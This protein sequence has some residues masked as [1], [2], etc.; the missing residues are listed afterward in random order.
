MKMTQFSKDRRSRGRT[1]K[2]STAFLLFLAACSPIPGFGQQSTARISA[3]TPS[4]FETRSAASSAA[5]PTNVAQ[6]AHSEPTPSPSP[7]AATSSP[8]QGLQY[9]S[10][11]QLTQKMVAGLGDALQAKVENGIVRIQLPG[12]VKTEGR[13][14][15]Q[16]AAGCELLVDRANNRYAL[17]GNPRSVKAWQKLLK[18]MDTL[19][20]KLS[21]VEVIFCE[22]ISSLDVPRRLS[23][24]GVQ[25]NPLASS[26]YQVSW[27]KGSGLSPVARAGF[28]EDGPA[29]ETEP[30]GLESLPEAQQ[31]PGNA[32]DDGQ[33]VEVLPNALQTPLPAGVKVTVSEDGTALVIEGTEDEIRQ[34]RELYQRLKE[35][36]EQSRPVFETYLLEN[37]NNQA[38]APV[39]QELYDTSFAPSLGPATIS[40]VPG[41]NSLVISGRPE[42]ITEIRKLVER[43]DVETDVAGSFRV[44]RPKYISAASAAN[45]LGSFFNV[46]V[47]QPGA[48]QGQFNNNANDI[49]SVL[50]IPDPRS[51]SIIIKAGATALAQA[52]KLLMEIDIVDAGDLP[53]QEV[54]IIPLRNSVAADMAQ[55]IQSAIN[56]QVPGAPTATT[57]GNNNNPFGGGFG[58]Q[59]LNQQGADPT[60]A[61]TGLRLKLMT[62]DDETGVIRSGI[63]FDIQITA[64]PTSNSLVVRGPAESLPLVEELINQLDRLPNAASKI[65]V[66]SIVNGDAAQLYDML[67]QLF[68]QGQQQGGGGGFNFGQQNTGLTR[69]PLQT[70]STVQTLV[71]LRFTL[72]PR[73]NSII[74]SGSEGDLQVVED[75]LTLLDR[76]NSLRFITKMVRLSNLPAEDMADSLNEWI[77]ARQGLYEADPA[78]AAENVVV[79]QQIVVTPEPISNTLMITASPQ[80][81]I[82]VLE[83]V[84]MLD[85]RPPMVQIKVMIAEVT[86][87]D[88]EEFGLQ[89]GVQDS[90]LFDRGIGDGIGYNFNQAAI[91]N[92][93]GPLGLASRELLAGQGLVNLGVGR[94]NSTLGYGGLVL[95]AGNE[96]ISVLLRALKDKQRIRALSNPVLMT[97]DNLQARVQ[98]GQKVPYIVGV[99]QN[100][101]GGFNN[102]VELQ[103]VG[104]ILDVVPR[105]S[106]DGMITM[107]VNAQN[108]SI[109]SEAN[110][111]AIAVDSNGNTVRQA[112][113]NI[114]LAVTT[115]LARSGQTVVLGGLIRDTKTYAK[116][117]IPVLSDLPRVGPLFSF[118]SENELRTELL[119]FLT[120]TLVE[121]DTEVACT[122]QAEMDRMHWCIDDVIDLHGPIGVTDQGSIYN[123]SSPVVV[124]PDI[125]PTGPGVPAILSRGQGVQPVP[126]VEHVPSTF[127]M[128]H[129]QPTGGTSDLQGG[130]SV[131]SAESVAPLDVAPN[132]VAPS[133][134]P[135]GGPSARK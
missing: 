95:S 57:F 25:L 10:G 93:L 92:S 53:V 49:Q 47:Q 59:G 66:F 43:L 100:T 90:I 81:M 120:P 69:L 110:G 32:Q 94:T 15:T 56:G 132:Q 58:Q 108:S 88:T 6:A 62:I 23:A 111:T 37:A 9:I 4:A 3:L 82:E 12:Q 14:M 117:G 102:S 48:N 98:V 121:D 26:V 55:V 101:L 16:S 63:L 125:N 78:T 54:K 109:G 84:R 87:N 115:V 33:N 68:Q 126:G 73:T 11:E 77:T 80:N 17:K 27:N 34:F 129:A 38:L 130:Y 96:S 75:L 119:F 39:L 135:P 44:L 106:P 97:I 2:L 104:V 124:Y 86:L 72:E 60:P 118:Q 28:Q 18:S 46:T 74:A 29:Q 1:A 41:E 64:D 52:Q 131:E 71:N 30:Q 13:P 40:A 122:N 134:V 45:R 76:E 51:N 133:E 8:I 91:G 85:R 128:M 20:A 5:V 112:P 50:I 67:T 116:R 42:A 114:T 70:G 123:D 105:V 107:L 61:A 103:D 22:E 31:E 127:E 99:N 65:K 21:S 36:A 7:V 24:A 89:F 19:E 83:Q 35:I 113:I 79:R